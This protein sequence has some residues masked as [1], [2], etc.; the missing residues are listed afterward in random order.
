MDMKQAIRKS[1]MESRTPPPPS[2]FDDKGCLKLDYVAKDKVEP[3]VKQLARERL[4]A[5]QLRRFFN[6]CRSIEQRL[7][8]RQTVWEQER[9]NIAK[10]SS[11]AAYAS[12]K[13][14]PIPPSFRRFIDDNV[15]MIRTEKDFLEGFMEHFEAVVGFAA[16]H[17]REERR[18]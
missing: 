17:V 9:A 13:T 1:G 2:Y 7:R 11:Q 10:L 15:E 6:H 5:H 16:L 8:S 18:R 3:L 4:K 12:Q 14:D